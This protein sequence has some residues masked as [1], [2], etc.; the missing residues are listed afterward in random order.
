V[1]YTF[2]DG[3]KYDKDGVGA[4]ASKIKQTRS[5]NGLTLYTTILWSDGTKSCDCPGWCILKKDK[6]GQPKPRACKHTKA[7]DKV[8]NTDMTAIGD[9]Q[10]QV[11]EVRT[12]QLQI[13][14]R[15]LRKIRMRK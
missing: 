10:P 14:E 1:E 12:P 7:S 6:S 15:Q 2:R 9:F 13:T 8:Q 11:G 5:S 4:D 3:R